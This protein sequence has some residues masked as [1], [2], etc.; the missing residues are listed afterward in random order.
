MGFLS[1]D[2]FIEPFMY[3]GLD[4]GKQK[5]LSL[6]RADVIRIICGLCG[7]LMLIFCLLIGTEGQQNADKAV[8]TIENTLLVSER[9]NT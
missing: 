3:K 2:K 1:G 9:E 4:T 5:F 8:A 7:T 6:R